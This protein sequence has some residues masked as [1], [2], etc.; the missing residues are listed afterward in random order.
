MKTTKKL[1]K[2]ILVKVGYYMKKDC[3]V[4]LIGSF[5]TLAEA[6]TAADDYEKTLAGKDYKREFCI[7]NEA[8]GYHKG[9]YFT[10]F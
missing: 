7:Y 6:K 4:E 2:R 5:D 8:D 10:I 3:G 1:N 9:F